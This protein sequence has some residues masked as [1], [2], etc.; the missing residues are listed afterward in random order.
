[1]VAVA[2][3]PA[4]TPAASSKIFGARFSGERKPAWQALGMTFDQSTDAVEA[5][6][7]A[8][9]NFEVKAVPFTVHLPTGDYTPERMAIVRSPVNGASEWDIIGY[10]SAKYQV[11]QNAR[12]AE[13]V[14]P[15]TGDWPVETIGLLPGGTGIFMVLDAGVGEVG[16]ESVNRRFLLVDSKQPGHAL[17]VAY[18]P[19]RVYC[20]NVLNTAFRAST[21]SAAL[22][23]VGAF[24]SEFN[25]RVDIMGKMRRAMAATMDVMQRMSEK[26]VTPKQVEQVLAAAYPDPRSSAKGRLYVEI[27][28]MAGNPETAIDVDG[29]YLSGLKTAS[30]R[31]AYLAQR[32]QVYRNGA[33]ELFT[34]MSDEHPQVAGTAWAIYNA[35]VESA[36]YRNGQGNESVAASVLFGPRSKEKERAWKAAAAL[37][38]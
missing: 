26:K 3:P 2:T 21:L 31:D 32:M 34:R 37:V 33:K 5:V 4:E 13:I 18:I 9:L 35:V 36:D 23:H 25:F 10:A 38:G 12:L 11:I 7:R 24:E 19:V 6:D 29:D 14:N 22:P 8:N 17:R 27:Q 28:D 16:G 30:E 20:Q 15:L 1:M